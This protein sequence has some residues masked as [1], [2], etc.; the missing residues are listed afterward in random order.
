MYKEANMKKIGFIGTGVMGGAMALN[1]LKNGYDVFIYNRTKAKAEH[2]IKAGATWCDTIQECVTNKEVIITI[3][4][5]PKDV[6]EVY[7]GKNG[8]FEHV[9]PNTIL[10]DMTTSSPAL[11]ERIYLKAKKKQLFSL[12][13]P[14]SGGDT[15]AK[16]ATLSIMVGGDKEIY[17]KCLDI[18]NTL[19][20]TIIYEGKAGFGQHTKMANQIAI[21]GTIAGV[22]EAIAYAKKKQLNLDTMFASISKGAAAST[23]LSANG[24]KMIQHDFEPG[25]YIKHFI[26]DMSIA[27]NES[28]ADN[29]N[30]EVL[31]LVRELFLKLEAQNLGDLGTQALI[32][33]YNNL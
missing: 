20:T 16:N 23:Q 27:Q 10:I 15:G 12:D 7:F 29:L 3:I 5:F 26:K 22:A 17:T 18:F 14:V 9:A 19:G 25:F 21:A 13:A 30:L 6:E 28:Q 32:K 1:L 24:L 33:N 8:I 11:A 31:N 2:L 4:G